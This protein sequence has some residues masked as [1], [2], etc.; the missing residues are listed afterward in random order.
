[1][2]LR[3]DGAVIEIPATGRG[4]TSDLA[5]DRAGRTPQFARWRAPQSSARW[6]AP[7][8][9]ARIPRLFLHARQR[10]DC[11]SSAEVPMGP[12]VWAAFRQNSE[13]NGFRQEQKH[14]LPTGA[15]TPASTP[16][17]SLE[18]PAAIPCQN[19]HRVS[20][21]QT[22]GRPGEDNLRRVD[23]S[24]FRLPVVICFSKV[25]AL[26]RPVESAAIRSSQCDGCLGPV[27][28]W[29]RHRD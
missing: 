9:S 18:R 20:R 28:C 6:R 12:D 21:C 2:P 3:G 10:K 7:R 4:V 22:G 16:A 11:G 1:M 29:V 23:R 14:R 17:S 15:E 8:S 19:R 5:G 27:L 24:D 13:T 25:G 26:R